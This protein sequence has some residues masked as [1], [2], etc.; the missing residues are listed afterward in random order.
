MVGYIF[1]ADNTAT[2]K[3]YFGK[4][5]SVKFDKTYL[6]DNPGVLEDVK[7]YGKDKFIVQMIVAC[8]TVKECDSKYES[9]LAQFN[10]KNDEN[11][12]NYEPKTETAP[13][14]KTRKKKVADK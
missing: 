7:K 2:G 5:Y 6:G 12:Y 1:R 11:W 14:K 3:H 13:V 9:I 8:E 4:Y 10:V